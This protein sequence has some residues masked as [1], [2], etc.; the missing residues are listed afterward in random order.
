MTYYHLYMYKRF[1]CSWIQIPAVRYL[2]WCKS[3]F[4]VG[5]RNW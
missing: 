1:I 2:L 5:L 3:S 4:D